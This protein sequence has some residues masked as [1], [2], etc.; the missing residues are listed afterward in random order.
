[1]RQ[2]KAFFPNRS[3]YLEKGGRGT[4]SEKRNPRDSTLG[5]SKNFFSEQIRKLKWNFSMF[6]SFDK[7]TERF[8]NLDAKC[9]ANCVSK[10]LKRI[11]SIFKIYKKIR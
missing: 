7:Q 9:G 8:S 11:E 10:I 3:S 5:R 1:M 2:K 6:S 4:A